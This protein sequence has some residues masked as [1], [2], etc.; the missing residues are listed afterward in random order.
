MSESNEPTY[1]TGEILIDAAYP[2][3]F[4]TPPASQTIGIKRL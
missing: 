3:P 1:L 4:E 2:A